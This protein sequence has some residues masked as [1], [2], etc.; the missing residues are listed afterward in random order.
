MQY[1]IEIG[2]RLEVPTFA[3][4]REIHGKRG[5]SSR[6]LAQIFELIGKQRKP[7]EVK[8]C[9]QHD[10]ERGKQ[11]SRTTYIEIREF[12]SGSPELRENEGRNE[13]ARD[14]EKYVNAYESA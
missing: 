14:D 6:M 9:R 10:G 5:S 11:A 7:T 3:P 4:D 1:G 13:K 12:E 8:A 2:S